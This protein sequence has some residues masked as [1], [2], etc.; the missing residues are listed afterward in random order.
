MQK[1]PNL[2]PKTDLCRSF[3]ALGIVREGH[4]ER[5]ERGAKMIVSTHIKNAAKTVEMSR[6]IVREIVIEGKP[7]KAIF[8]RVNGYPVSLLRGEKSISTCVCQGFMFRSRCKH[9][10]HVEMIWRRYHERD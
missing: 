5:N 4:P 2:E 3:S 10:Y 8:A 9:I 1:A 6:Y 7:Y